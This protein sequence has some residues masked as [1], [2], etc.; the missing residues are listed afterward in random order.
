MTTN[1]YNKHRNMSISS[2]LLSVQ[3]HTKKYTT[4]LIINYLIINKNLYV[5]EVAS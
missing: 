2:N 1:E 3:R 4:T 5:Q